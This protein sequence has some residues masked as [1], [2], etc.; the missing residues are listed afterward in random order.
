MTDKQACSNIFIRGVNP[1]LL[2]RY[3]N[4]SKTN[5]IILGRD[6]QPSRFLSTD[7]LNMKLYMK[8]RVIIDPTSGYGK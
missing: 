6:E 3:N 8:T 7:T 1:L 4:Y 5:L 2:S